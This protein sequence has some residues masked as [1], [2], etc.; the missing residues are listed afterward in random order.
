MKSDTASRRSV[1]AFDTIG[2]FVRCDMAHKQ[3]WH[4]YVF[5]HRSKFLKMAL[6]GLTTAGAKAQ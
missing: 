6:V 1:A 4:D 5:D 2:Q 3:S